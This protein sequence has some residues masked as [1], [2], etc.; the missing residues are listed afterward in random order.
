MRTGGL[1][2]MVRSVLGGA[3][4]SVG[5]SVSGT[6]DL[7]VPTRTAVR[8]PRGRSTR[9]VPTRIV[10][11]LGTVRSARGGPMRTGGLVL[12]VRSVLGGASMSVG[13]GVSGTSGPRGPM[14]IAVRVETVRSVLVASTIVLAGATR[15][16]G[17]VGRTIAL[18]APTGRVPVTTA[19]DVRL[20]RTTIGALVVRV[21]T[22]PGAPTTTGG[23]AVTGR[24]VRSGPLTIGVPV[25]RVTTDPGASMTTA[26]L[27]AS[28]RTAALGGATTSVARDGIARTDRVARSTVAVGRT[29]ISAPIAVSDRARTGV[30]N[31]RPIRSCRRRSSSRCSPARRARR[32]AG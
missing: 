12:M 29:A 3:S 21:M 27:G 24:S 19:R 8:V 15:I 26:P 9:G 10:G 22:G 32:C 1:V 28:G 11:R 18:D 2:V 23:L 20:V 7:R 17:P 30:P 6:S 14:T 31:A 16:G 4:M 25:V 5:H 13:H